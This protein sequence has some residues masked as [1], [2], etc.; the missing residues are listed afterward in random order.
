MSTDGRGQPRLDRP[1][2][3]RT[4][5]EPVP[6]LG[7][8]SQ[9]SP[10]PPG[11]V[12]ELHLAILL[13]TASCKPLGARAETPSTR[14]PRHPRRGS[15]ARQTSKESTMKTVSTL[16]GS[17]A[18]LLLSAGL[19]A[20]APCTTG[21]TTN[22]TSHQAGDA[23]SNVDGGSTANVTPGAKAE[24]PGTVGAMNNVGAQAKPSTNQ[25]KAPEGKVIK[26]GDDDC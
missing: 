24:S 11:G 2:T 22:S 13:A 19:A 3:S 15:T 8:L 23:S 10:A 16:T 4:R 6:A 26:P 12:T 20:A 9:T 14:P 18:A 25:A 1:F 21:T 17:I 5:S 7:V